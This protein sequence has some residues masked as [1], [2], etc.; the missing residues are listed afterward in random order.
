[1]ESDKESDRS[2]ELVSTL[3]TKSEMV[4]TRRSSRIKEMRKEADTTEQ[5]VQ[6]SAGEEKEKKR[7]AA[8]SNCRRLVVLTKDL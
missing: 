6:G 2:P 7:L 4:S 8:F 1:M 3:E 5:T